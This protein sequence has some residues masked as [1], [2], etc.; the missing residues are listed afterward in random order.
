MIDGSRQKQTEIFIVEKKYE[1]LN[2]VFVDLVEIRILF[3]TYTTS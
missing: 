1:E 2:G 3:R